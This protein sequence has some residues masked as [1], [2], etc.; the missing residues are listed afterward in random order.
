MKDE[1]PH[2]ALLDA[3]GCS[4]LWPG[5]WWFLEMQ[6]LTCKWSAWVDLEPWALLHPSLLATAPVANASP[7]MIVR[8]Q[9][10]VF[11]MLDFVC[12]IT[13]CW[14]SYTETAVH[15][16]GCS[17]QFCF[18]CFEETHWKIQSWGFI[19]FQTVVHNRLVIDLYRPIN[20]VWICVRIMDCSSGLILFP[21]FHKQMFVLIC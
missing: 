15:V 19:T 13:T 6:P 21:Q 16:F 2:C 4:S 5:S 18:F 12:G 8:D 20:V 3:G 1:S 14:F 17:K 9:W 7:H 10:V 11:V